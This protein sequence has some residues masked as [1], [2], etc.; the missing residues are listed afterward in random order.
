M[1]VHLI[2]FFV[3]QGELDEHEKLVEAIRQVDIVIV[4]LGLPLIMTQLKIITAMQEAGNV[5]VTAC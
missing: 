2:H 3:Q 5:K 4:T 1:V